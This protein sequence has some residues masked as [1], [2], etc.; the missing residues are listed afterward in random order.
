MKKRAIHPLWGGLCILLVAAGF[1]GCVS[2]AQEKADALFPRHEQARI[3][4][5][6]GLSIEV[7]TYDGEELSAISSALL[8]EL[9][10]LTPGRHS[11]GFYFVRS[12][13]TSVAGPTTTS[14]IY[15]S[16]NFSVTSTSTSRQNY[17]TLERVSD[18]LTVENDFEAGR[19]YALVNG[20]D[21]KP[22]VF[23]AGYTD[24]FWQWRVES[25]KPGE[26]LVT[27]EDEHYQFA[28]GGWPFILLIDGER[29]LY[30]VVGEEKEIVLS[31][32]RHT[33]A[34]IDKKDPLSE[35]IAA[36]YELDIGSEEA[37]IEIR[38]SGKKFTLVD[39]A[40]EEKAADD[41]AS[42]AKKAVALSVKFPEAAG[43]AVGPGESILEV[44][45][46]Y[47]FEPPREPLE[48]FVDGEPV[49]R[50]REKRTSMR[51]R[52]PNGPHEIMAKNTNKLVGQ[53]TSEEFKA[54]SNL[55]RATLTQGLVFS[56]DIEIEE[57]PLK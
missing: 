50:T 5:G 21:G 30:F 13:T 20:G 18:L 42:A 1:S 3:A 11:V 36:S 46:D 4:G 19:L 48:I 23:D 26:T 6:G 25:K 14:T 32:G 41:A 51:F 31:Q 16:G 54:N 55:I 53:E 22:I 15:N 24:W 49:M 7:T 43:N 38:G 47:T 56:D 44:I 45:I 35:T 40:V 52:V 8:W 57:R 28:Q 12:G 33:F 39:A 34:V 9:P 2:S 10:G 29:A 17:V 37:G 27:I